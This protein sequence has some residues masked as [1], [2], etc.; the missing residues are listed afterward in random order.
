MTLEALDL[1]SFRSPEEPV[2]APFPLASDE[3]RPPGA[4]CGALHHV[5]VWI[6]GSR[7]M[8]WGLGFRHLGF[9]VWGL[10]I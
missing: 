6:S 1:D 7:F 9:R 2:P 3:A 8:D 10:G 5:P 4:H